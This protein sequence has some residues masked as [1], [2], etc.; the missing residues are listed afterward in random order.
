[1][2]GEKEAL[3]LLARHL[4]G[5]VLD[6]ARRLARQAIRNDGLI[7]HQDIDHVLRFKYDALGAGSV[8]SPELDTASFA[9]VGGVKRL[10][11]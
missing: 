3:H 2:R 7:T 6:D 1:M 5:M 8:L 9:Q 10:K 11:H 4:S